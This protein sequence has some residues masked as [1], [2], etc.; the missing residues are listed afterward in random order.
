MVVVAGQ[1]ACAAG[2]HLL[3]SQ[4]VSFGR[5]GLNEVPISFGRTIARRPAS[6]ASDG[7]GIIRCYK[8]EE[9]TLSANRLSPQRAQLQ[10]G[11]IKMKSSRRRPTR[12]HAASFESSD[13]SNQI[14]E[15]QPSLFARIANALTTAFPVWV[16]LSCALALY[17]P[18]LFTWI[19]VSKQ[20]PHK[21]S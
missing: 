21:G 8:D 2:Q 4:Q 11:L 13:A 9:S 1:R 18:T 3:Q 14:A 20:A 16:A 5:Q 17:W 7:A 19:Q 10:E 12:A 15:G 6:H